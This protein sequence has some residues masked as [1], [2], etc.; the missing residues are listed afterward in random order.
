MFA[1]F[2]RTKRFVITGLT[3]GMTDIHTHL[4]PGVDDGAKDPED[5]LRILQYLQNIGV[6]RVFFTPR[7][8]AN[9]TSN[10][11]AYL[12]EQ[13]VAFQNSVPKGIAVRLAAEYML[14]TGF[15]SHLPDGLLSFDGKHVLVEM[16]SLLV[17]PNL[18][19]LLYEM[20]VNNYIP[21]VA[22]PEHYTSMKK[23]GYNSLKRRGCKFQ[24]DLLSL[25]GYYGKQSKV[26]SEELLRDDK[27]DFVGSDICNMEHEQAYNNFLLTKETEL[28][29]RKLLD[30]NEILWL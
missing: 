27:Y 12:K 8:V 28:A 7:V 18:Y 9:L 24:L 23:N 19:E 25:S 11:A 1:I 15:L 13:F 2:R 6:R 10:R 20:T 5:S 4:L 14:D 30:R 17:P 26:C 16:S 29:L 3:D 22:H 21:V